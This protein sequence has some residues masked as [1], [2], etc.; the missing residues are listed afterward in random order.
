MLLLEG[1]RVGLQGQQ[2]LMRPEQLKLI[3]IAD[4]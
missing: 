2:L 4:A 1:E 3:E